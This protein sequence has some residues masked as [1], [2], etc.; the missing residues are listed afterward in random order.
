MYVAKICLNSV[1]G[2]PINFILG[3]DITTTPQ[4]VGHKT[5]SCPHCHGNQCCHGNGGTKPAFY[6][7]MYQKLKGL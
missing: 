1:L 2:G 7:R 6:D 4:Q 3:A 5:V